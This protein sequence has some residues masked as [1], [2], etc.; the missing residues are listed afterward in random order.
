MIKGYRSYNQWKKYPYVYEKD[1]ITLK[2]TGAYITNAHLDV[3]TFIKYQLHIGDDISYSFAFDMNK[4]VLNEF[5]LGEYFVNSNYDSENNSFHIEYIQREQN[6]ENEY[7]ELNNLLAFLSCN[8]ILD[9]IGLSE[10]DI[11]SYYVIVEMV[12]FSIRY[13]DNELEEHTDWYRYNRESNTLH[14]VDVY[15]SKVEIPDITKEGVTDAYYEADTLRVAEIL[16]YQNAQWRPFFSFEDYS[17]IEK[18]KQKIISD[19]KVLVDDI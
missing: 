9:E 3:Y 15:D 19:L 16:G 4:E 5:W 10:S 18:A 8:D 7:L 11:H 17:Y 14:Y 6:Y 1:Y 2:N 13:L 12:Y